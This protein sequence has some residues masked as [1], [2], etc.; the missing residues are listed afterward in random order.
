[1]ISPAN[2]CV[3]RNGLRP[4]PGK[5]KMDFPWS[6]Y[7]VHKLEL[8]CVRGSRTLLIRWNRFM[9]DNKPRAVWCK[10]Q[11]NLGSPIDLFKGLS[12]TN[13]TIQRIPQLRLPACFSECACHILHLVR[14]ITDKIHIR[15]LACPERGRG[16]CIMDIIKACPACPEHGRGERSLP[17]AKS[18]GRGSCSRCFDLNFKVRLYSYL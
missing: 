1:M 12:F 17:R 11:G 13:V 5:V 10:V 6:F 3:K 16:N 18:W 2:Q 9:K 14:L 15:I 8:R 7:C 4:A